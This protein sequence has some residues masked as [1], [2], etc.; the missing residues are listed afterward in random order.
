MKIFGDSI[1]TKVVVGFTLALG[2]V[3][4][5]IFLTYTSFT[6]LLNSVEVLSQPNYKLRELQHTL[7]S[8][9]TAESAI[10]AYTLTTNEKHFKA[11]LAHLDTIGSQIDSLEHLMRHNPL[12][13]AQVDSISALLQAK[14][15]SLAQYVALKKE[16]KRYN[17]S[18]K[19]MIQIASTVEQTPLSTTISKHTKTTISDRLDMNGT[20]QEAQQP[21]IALPQEEP[22][23]VPEK[24]KKEKRGFFNRIFS[25][26]E[27]EEQPEPPRPK[28]IVPQ[29]EVRQETRVDTSANITPVAPLSKV[30]RILHNVQRE[31]DAQEQKLQQKELA[32]LQQD[33]HIMDQIRTMIYQLE[34]HEQKQTLRNSNQARAVAKQTSTVLLVIGIA[35]LVSGV[36]FIL[37]ILHDIT[38]S[39]NYRSSLIKAQKEA[40]KLARA[41]EA[42]VANMS[43]EMRTPLNVI[44]GFSQQLHHTPLLPQQQEHLQAVSGAGQHLLHIVNDVLD[45]SKMEAGKLYINR[46]PFS[47]SQLLN[48]VEQAFALKATGKNIIFNYRLSTSIPDALEGDLLRMKQILFNLVDNAIK[49]THKGL[50]Q[51]QVDLRSRRRNRLVLSIAVADTGIGMSEES[52]QYVFGEFNQADSSI[53]RKYGGTGL[54]LSISKKLVEMQGGTLSVNSMEGEGTTFT[55]L[56][57]VQIAT[58]AVPAAPRETVPVPASF[59]GLKALVIDDDGYSRTL[60]DLILS[61]WGMVVHLANDGPEA[62]ALAQEHKYDVVL[63]DIQLPGISG[64][65]VARNIHKLDPEVPIIALT[66]NIMS[67]DIGFFKNTGITDHL[68]KPYK[69]QE[70]HQKLAKVLPVAAIKAAEERAAAS[71]SQP[72]IQKHEVEQ[73]IEQTNSLYSL[74][75]MRLFTGDDTQAL[76]AVVEVLLEDQEQN[77]EQLSLAAE[78][79]D[80]EATATMAHKMLTAFKHL[81][82]HTVT[83][84]LLQLEQVLHTGRQA[85]DE[86][87]QAV[88]QAQQ[89]VRLV[90]NALQQE[91]HSLYAEQPV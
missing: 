26:K 51:V 12:E 79:A 2:I 65:T 75:E 23:V 85:P 18:R 46:S 1:K 86:L 14:Q 82:A 52:L 87:Q 81:Q 3:V 70:L 91:L 57:P 4:A 21:E 31:A 16:Q 66:A 41:K 10:R 13:K 11:Y 9:S 6:K 24:E 27:K 50:V 19:A 64:K 34:R 63:T 49:F 20:R 8:I 47:I 84:H 58:E 39:N 69:E 5:A 83:P 25:K 53:L 88:E 76:A 7:G 89:Q 56:L 80:W 74:H 77:L 73:P 28:V 37:L 22:V 67:N 54:G 78:K 45:L 90:L 32:L 35:G 44:L 36:G 68:L 17:Y 29:L 42:F 43:H 15:Q 59:K 60:C 48:E 33:K 40:V 55:V 71:E 61:R 62:L 30:R 38:R 72:V